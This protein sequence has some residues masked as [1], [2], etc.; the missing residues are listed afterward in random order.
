MISVD[1]PV[2][3]SRTAVAGR[4]RYYK[5]SEEQK[6]RK[7]EREKQR[8][9]ANLEAFKQRDRKYHAANRERRLLGRTCRAP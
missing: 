5:L 4:S 3:R 2:A 1:L 9:L 7:R 6:K 8:R